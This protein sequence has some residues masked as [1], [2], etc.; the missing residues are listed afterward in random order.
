MRWFGS[1][2]PSATLI[3][4]WML[5]REVR[6]SCCFYCCI[7]LATVMLGLAWCVASESRERRCWSQALSMPDIKKLSMPASFSFY[8]LLESWDFIEDLTSLLSFSIDLIYRFV[9]SITVGS[10]VVYTWPC[11]YFW[12]VFKCLRT[13]ES[14]YIWVWMSDL[15]RLTSRSCEMNFWARSYDDLSLM[16]RAS[17]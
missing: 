7:F 12:S 1:L 13:C 9:Y 10:F 11:R 3:A 4:P 17:I 14:I 15:S 16:E 2:F 5:S 8:V 6:A